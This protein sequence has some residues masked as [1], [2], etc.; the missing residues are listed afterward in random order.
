MATRNT[1][2]AVGSDV[3]N[4][5]ARL[6]NDIDKLLHTRLPANA[7]AAEN[8][9]PGANFQIGSRLFT[10]LVESIKLSAACLTL[11]FAIDWSFSR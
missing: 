3:A 7:F 9:D 1:P 2:L 8:V 5:S 6:E 4:A 10:R 11:L